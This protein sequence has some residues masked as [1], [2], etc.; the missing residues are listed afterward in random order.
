MENDQKIAI[1]IIDTTTAAFSKRSP[2]PVAISVP[3]S[4]KLYLRPFLDG[5]YLL[6]LQN[7]D[8]SQASV[9]LPDGWTAT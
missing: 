1:N 9:T 5:T 4:V 8:K 7:F 2:S 6:R 3:Q